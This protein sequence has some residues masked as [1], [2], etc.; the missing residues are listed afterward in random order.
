MGH[1][2]GSK[3]QA[4]DGEARVPAPAAHCDCDPGRRLHCLAGHAAPPRVIGTSCNCKAST[5]L[6]TAA[7]GG[8]GR[9]PSDLT[10]QVISYCT[11]TVS[12]H[13]ENAVI[14]YR[15]GSVARVCRGLVAAHPASGP[16][17]GMASA[18]VRVWPP[19]S[20]PPPIPPDI[21]IIWPLSAPT[22][23]VREDHARGAGNAA[24][25]P[26]LRRPPTRNVR[27][28]INGRSALVRP[29]EGEHPCA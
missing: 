5:G 29:R 14:K 26:C 11:T 15:I 7:R 18:G 9:D 10:A 20:S 8:R 4:R 23:G 13:T 12:G 1:Q 22:R 27:P 19:L 24:R 6:C 2:T 21:L 16:E 17:T 3:Q 28:R 25:R